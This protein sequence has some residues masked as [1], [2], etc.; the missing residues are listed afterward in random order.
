MLRV[1]KRLVEWVPASEIEGLRAAGWRP[2][3]KAL[4]YDDEC[5]L[6]GRLPPGYP[7]RFNLPGGGV[8]EGQSL[9]EAL[10]RECEEELEGPALSEADVCH[11]RILAEGRLPYR[12]DEFLGKY[13][14]VIG[15][16]ATSLDYRTLGDSK[17]VLYP[18]IRRGLAYHF[19]SENREMDE[20]SRCLYALALE[21][22]QTMS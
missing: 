21:T 15:V 7:M 4:I 19:V 10:V 1:G 13:E 22:L 2:G 17:L 12:R 8:D 3:I 6:I 5:V 16:R 11:S 18:P 9:A 14:Y 20:A